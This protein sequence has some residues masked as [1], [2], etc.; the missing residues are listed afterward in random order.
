ML[1]GSRLRQ[2]RE[3]LSL[4]QEELG[5]MVGVSKVSICG[6]EQETRIPSLSVFLALVQILKVDVNYLL[7][8]DVE[9][10]KETENLK[11]KMR[12]EDLKILSEIKKYPELYQT[13]LEEP[14]RTIKLI[15]KKLFE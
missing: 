2:A 11:V 15:N 7:G 14:S 12:N 4:S 3:N 10:I 6:Y 5:D 13:L 8:Y 9:V 1:I